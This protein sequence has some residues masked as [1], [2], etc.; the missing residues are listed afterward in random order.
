MFFI[1]YE[2]K[3]KKFIQKLDFSIK[4]RVIKRIKELEMDPFPR[5][6]QHIL[7]T[8]G[9]SLLCELAIDKLRI[10]YTVEDRFI[11][12]ENIEYEGVVT[13]V[14]G[15]SNHKSGSKKNWSNQ[16]ND[17]QKLIKWFK[18]LFRF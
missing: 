5:N 1:K 15:S 13:L 11:V 7:E 6:K 2:E 8:A 4:K 9:S 14:E 12:I 3:A 16:R 17:I 10:Y 18:N